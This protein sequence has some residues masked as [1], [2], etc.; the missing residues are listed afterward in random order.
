MKTC[1]V[2]LLTVSLASFGAASPA[3]LRWRNWR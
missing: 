3:L 1:F 2:Y